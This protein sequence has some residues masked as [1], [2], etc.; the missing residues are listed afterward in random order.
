MACSCK[1][2]KRISEIQKTYGINNKQTV[3][4]DIVGKIRIITKQMLL[5]FLCL[6][7]IPFIA[8]FI[9]LRGFFTKKPISIRKIFKIGR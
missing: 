1:I 5:I 2:D 4:T 8:L 6:P 7:F 3:K 9:G